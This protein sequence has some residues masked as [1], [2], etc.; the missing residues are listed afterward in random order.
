MGHHEIS[1]FH[2][3]T[4]LAV[5]G[6][7]IVYFNMNW[8]PVSTTSGRIVWPLFDSSQILVLFSVPF[9]NYNYYNLDWG[10]RELYH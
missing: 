3:V 4:E 9:N 10:L 5:Q 1:A 8:T 6:H 2:P 7:I